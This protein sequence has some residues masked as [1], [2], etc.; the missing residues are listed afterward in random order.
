MVES[1]CLRCKQKREMSQYSEY[2]SPNGVWMAKGVCPV[3][4][5]KMAKILG[6]NYKPQQQNN[7]EEGG[8][9]EPPSP[10]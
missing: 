1:Y 3:C 5:T 7:P 2:K 10:F 6:K 9:P 8:I 4:G